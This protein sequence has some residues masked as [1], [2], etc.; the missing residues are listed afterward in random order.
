MHGCVGEPI[1]P[2][3]GFQRDAN[4]ETVD[5][6]TS[7]DSTFPYDDDKMHKMIQL[8]RAAKGT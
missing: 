3:L 7:K 2:G 1:F 4:N 6:I 5:V 8:V